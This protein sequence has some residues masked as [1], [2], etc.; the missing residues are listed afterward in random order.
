MSHLAIYLFGGF[1]AELDGRPLTTFGTD[2]NRALLAYLAFESGRPHRR[3]TLATLLW[4]DHRDA[5][6]RNS[7]RQALYHLRH[8]IPQEV[9]TETHLLI[10]REQVQFNPASDHWIDFVEFTDRLSAC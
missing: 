4:S 5:V 6:A 1:R 7:L 2:K 9:N 3:E 8:L 10:T